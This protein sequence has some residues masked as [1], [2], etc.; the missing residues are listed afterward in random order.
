M[1]RFRCRFCSHVYDE[2]LGDPETGVAPGTL[3][4]D[5]P[6]EW[7]CPECG[8]TKEDYDLIDE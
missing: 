8:A 1:R 2:R 4:N 7:M 6:E 5:L 3:F